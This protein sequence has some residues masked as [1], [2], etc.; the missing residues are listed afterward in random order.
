MNERDRR[1]QGERRIELIDRA[2]HPRRRRSGPAP[3]LGRP[4][5][6]ASGRVQIKWE[7]GVGVGAREALSRAIAAAHA[8]VARLSQ[9]QSLARCFI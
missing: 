7:R 9:T 4:A 2:R 1:W 3:S 5:E 8:R 6:W